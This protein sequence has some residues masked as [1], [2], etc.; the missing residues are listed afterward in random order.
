MT[1]QPA[2]ALPAFWPGAPYAA[3][4]ELAQAAARMNGRLLLV[5]GAV[6]DALLGLPSSDL[7]LE[8]FGLHEQAARSLLKS[9]GG[10]V[11]VGMAF[12]VWRHTELG[13]DL[14]LPRKERPRGSRH[15]DFEI[16][17]S[18]DLSVEE[19]SRRR[20]FTLNAIAFDPL[21][22][23]LLDPWGGL[24]DL[25]QG[26]LR[27]V[28]EQFAEDPLRVL[29]AMQ[30]IARFDLICKPETL[31][32]C[33]S[34]DSAHLPR[35]RVGAEWEKLLLHG[36]HPSRGLQFLRQ[37]GWLDD[38][39]ELQALIDCPQDPQWHPEGDVWTHTLLCL[40]ASVPLRTGIR[41]DDLIVALAVLCHDLGKAT[42]TQFIDGRWRSPGHEYAGIAPARELLARL[43][44][45]QRI[46]NGVLPLVETHMRPYQLFQTKASDSAVRRLSLKAKRLDLLIRVSTADCRGRGGEANDPFP[47]GDW[48]Q[49]KAR[50]LAVS[51]QEPKPILLGRHLMA[52]GYR[53]GRAMGELLDELFD[54]QLDGHFDSIETGIEFAKKT[55]EPPG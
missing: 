53:P 1:L 6:R 50:A 51:D 13:I 21:S 19:A 48:L 23:E 9:F 55:L 46:I 47:A 17:V 5:G 11:Y 24:Q 2:S 36:K 52:L 34:L 18:P 38:Y 12:P 4:R 14:A 26:Q 43:T 27:H 28:S 49:E 37:C 29:R 44:G 40:D 15:Q 39:P 42:H 3:T 41:D 54:Q 31:A 30:F 22:E 8:L 32:L 16:E 20:D 33:Q 7:D 35:E 10:F 25:G 45:E